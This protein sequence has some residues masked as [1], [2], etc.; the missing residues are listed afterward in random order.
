[1]NIAYRTRSAVIVCAAL[2]AAVAASAQ[3]PPSQPAYPS[4]PQVT[5]NR[6]VNPAQRNTQREQADGPRCDELTG[7]ERA[8]CE[9]RD[10]ANDDAPAGVTSG[11]R[12]REKEEK[13][14]AETEA[15]ATTTAADPRS[16]TAESR[17]SIA[18][19]PPAELPNDSDLDRARDN[20]DASDESEPETQ[21]SSDS[22][23]DTLGER[24]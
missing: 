21:N 23:S 14:K 18:R 13:A 20:Q 11:M 17:T 2:G 24:K 15:A 1:M 12:E 16:D 3:T 9:R 19:R 5:P 10:V 4:S 22:D 7:L 6:G 8:E